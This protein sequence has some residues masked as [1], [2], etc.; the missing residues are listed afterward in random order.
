[1]ICVDGGARSPTQ[2]NPHG[3][4]N[5]SA[6]IRVIR[7]RFT[8]GGHCRQRHARLNR[9]LVYCH[10]IC[11][12]FC[13][14]P[15]DSC[16]LTPEKMGRPARNREA[17]ALPRGFKVPACGLRLRLQPCLPPALN[18]PKRPSQTT[19]WHRTAAWINRPTRQ[20]HRSLSNRGKLRIF[21]E[22]VFRGNCAPRHGADAPRSPR[23]PRLGRA[24]GVSLLTRAPGQ[25]TTPTPQST[26]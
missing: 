9:P 20:T 8:G 1:V 17:D 5:A 12:C 16:L 25:L 13:S 3:S 6:L 18:R 11:V 26:G 23:C 21:F 2:R 19:I 14:L 22:V 7:G 10:V 15:P 4:R 24:A